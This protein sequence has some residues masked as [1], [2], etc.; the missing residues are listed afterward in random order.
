[1]YVRY[2][3]TEGAYEMIHFKNDYP[4]NVIKNAKAFARALANQEQ[5]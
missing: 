5:I 1:M 4:A 2:G 3:Q